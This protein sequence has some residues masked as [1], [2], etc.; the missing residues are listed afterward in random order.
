MEWRDPEDKLLSMTCKLDNCFNRFYERLMYCIELIIKFS[1][2][3]VSSVLCVVLFLFILF[4]QFRCKAKS[5]VST[6]ELLDRGIKKS[7]QLFSNFYIA[8]CTTYYCIWSDS[9]SFPLTFLSV[10]SSYVIKI[11]VMWSTPKRYS[12]YRLAK[13]LPHLCTFACAVWEVPSGINFRTSR[14]WESARQSRD[15]NKE[16]RDVAVAENYVT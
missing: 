4:V 12:L 5:K 1:C 16:E 14:L 7:S 15:N 11:S 10:S 8:F 6:K 13:L 3:R 9:W 2:N